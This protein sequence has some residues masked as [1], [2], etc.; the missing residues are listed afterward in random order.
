MTLLFRELFSHISIDQNAYL[1][2]KMASLQ[3]V[4]A[5]PRQ[6]RIKTHLKQLFLA[7]TCR[8]NWTGTSASA[9]ASASAQMIPDK[10]KSMYDQVIHTCQA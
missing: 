7:G 4:L 1:R 9:S 6:I 5:L 2:V 3:D 10:L 8:R